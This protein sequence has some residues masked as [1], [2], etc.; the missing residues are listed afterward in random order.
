MLVIELNLEITRSVQTWRLKP[1]SDATCITTMFALYACFSY[2]LY[3]FIFR[4][5]GCRCDLFLSWYGTQ[6][7]RI[8]WDYLKNS[9][10]WGCKWFLSFTT[11][12]I[13]YFLPAILIFS[14]WQV[15]IN[16]GPLLYHFAD[17]YNQEDV[18]LLIPK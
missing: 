6:H 4:S 16:L 2:L 10:R 17:M 1:I 3:L 11:S 12:L 8:Y 5:L 13:Q 7:C 15:W 18:S 9:Q 14:C